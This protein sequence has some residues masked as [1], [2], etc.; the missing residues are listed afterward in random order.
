[1]FSTKHTFTGANGHQLAARLDAPAGPPRAYALFAHCFTCGKD[2]AAA[3]R[4]ARALAARNI[5]VLRFDFAGLGQSEGEF[6]ATN[7]SSNVADLQAAAAYMRAE[8]EAPRILIGHSLGGAAVLA[9]AG[10]LP[11]V[12]AVATLAA[13]FEPAHVTHLFESHLEAIAEDGEAEVQL[14][15]RPFRI[16]QQFIDDV[17]GQRQAERIRTLKRALLVMHSPTD[18][19]VG[20]DNAAHIYKAAKHPKS[21]VSLD[22]TDHLIS[23][24]ADADY[25]ATVLSAWASRY[26]P[27]QPHDHDPPAEGEVRVES[28]GRGKFQQCVHAGGATFFADEPKSYGGDASG[29]TPYDLLLAGLGACT[30][31]TMKMYADRKGWPLEAAAVVLTHRK[32]HA[33]DCETCESENGQV[34]VI[35]RRIRL[36][37]ALDADQRQRILA[38]AD[39]CPVHRTL[40]GEVV[41]KTVDAG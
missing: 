22:G 11:E 12:Q 18:Q 28:T 32:I 7:F 38:I 15:G 30:S 39:R 41:I 16:Q 23:K 24:I 37:G 34:D 35:E 36:D 31:M 25:V 8:L 19:L 26:V 9:A 10:D 14:A 20:I 2:I 1:M 33:K 27:E 3:G 6:A 21:F 5:A 17:E 40:H 13:P 4:I 29:P